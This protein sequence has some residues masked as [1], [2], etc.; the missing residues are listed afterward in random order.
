[1]GQN[2][3]IWN[4]QGYAKKQIMPYMILRFIQEDTIRYGYSLHIWAARS[5]EIPGMVSGRNPGK[6]WRCAPIEL[7]FHIRTR[8]NGWVLKL[9]RK[10]R[11]FNHKKVVNFAY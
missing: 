8:E 2:R 6:I 11:L 10:I 7:N 3:E 9:C 4:C 1:M 5:W